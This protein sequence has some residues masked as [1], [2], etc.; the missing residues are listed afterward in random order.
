MLNF[1]GDSI[2]LQNTSGGEFSQKHL[3]TDPSLLFQ[4]HITNE[5]RCAAGTLLGAEGRRRSAPDTRTIAHGTSGHKHWIRKVILP[6]QSSKKDSIFKPNRIFYSS[7][8]DSPI[9]KTEGHQPP[10]QIA[11][12][13]ISLALNTSRDGA[14]TTSL[15]RSYRD[16]R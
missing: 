15:G 16:E 4:K 14:S 5:S 10:D 12:S 8:Y 6:S 1:Y 7:M 13:H 3:V 11:Q 9:F 2:S